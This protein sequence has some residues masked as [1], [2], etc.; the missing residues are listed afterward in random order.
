MLLPIGHESQHSRRLPWIT[1]AILVAN[2]VVFFI[3]NRMNDAIRADFVARATAAV[4]YY[5][6]HPYL[7]PG[8]PLDQIV[9][10]PYMAP[11]AP[12]SVVAAEQGELDRMCADLVA[13]KGRSPY[14]RFGYVPAKKNA[15]GLITSQFLHGGWLHIIFNMWFLWL[16]GCNL[17]DAWGRLLFPVLYVSAGVVAIFAHALGAPQS[18]VPLIGASGAVAG[19]MGAFA[20]RFGATKI[21]FMWLLFF[22]PVFFNARAYLMLP[23]WALSEAFSGSTNPNGGGGGV[24]HWA[25][26]GGFAYGLAFAIVLRVIGL[27]KRLDQAIERKVSFEQDPRL[28]EASDLTTRGTPDAAFPLLD[29]MAREAPDKIEV[30]LELLRAS[31]KAGDEARAMRAYGRLIELYLHDGAAA[32]AL[33]LFFEVKRS[34]KAG[35]LPPALR[36][37][38]GR[39]LERDQQGRQAAE[40]YESIHDGQG[41]DDLG[42]QALLSHAQLALKLGQKTEAQAL[43]Q[44]AQRSPVPHLE[45]EGL[46]ARGLRDAG[47]P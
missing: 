37:R 26:V 29:A 6:D 18:T 13:L 11:R 3:T 15:L 1:I 41:R 22:R 8:P 4:A 14:E 25:H 9:S 46:I 38:L 20:L 44:A 43:F 27:D 7:R 39:A 31:L 33:D 32:T 21:R 34:G 35:R 23:L 28:V 24:A 47:A 42:L 10:V 2:F 19:A 5:Q 36:M 45:L 12:A 17:E 40:I 16:V 30:H